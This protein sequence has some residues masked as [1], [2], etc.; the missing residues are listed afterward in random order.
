MG[1]PTKAELARQLEALRKSL[2]R[3][4]KSGV[5][6]EET[7]AEALERQTATAEILRVIASSPGDVQPVFDAIVA[8]AARLC[9][10]EFSAVTKF[11][12]GLLHLVAM[13]NMSPEEAAAYRSIFPRAPGRNFAIGR[14]FVDARPA[15]IRD[16]SKDPDYDPYTLQVL[17]QAAPYRTY[18]G[19]PILRD[20][21]PIGAIGCGR[22]KVKPFTPAQIELVKTF[23]D[24]AVIA[25][26]NVRLFS[27]LQARNADLTE[28]LEQQ[29]ATS[30]ILR[31]ISQ[32]PTDLQPV[33]VAIAANAAGLCD[34]YDAQ[35]FRVEGDSLR[36][37]GSHGP[38]PSIGEFP[39][40]RGNPPGRAVIDRRPIHVTDLAAEADTE[41]PDT[42][43]I[44][45]E[46][47]IRTVLATPLV[48]RGYEVAIA[49]DGEQGLAMARSEAPALILMDMSLPGI[50]GWEATRQLKAAPET[51][52]I[53]IIALTAHAMAGDRERAVA[54]GCDD[55]DTK[56]VELTRLLE[57]IEALLGQTGNA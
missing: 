13:N 32:S 22:R 29:T 5:R 11:E 25:I 53:P 6:L 37:V 24:Q 42:R 20:G 51:Q 36:H 46:L 30:E 47:G 18:L 48:R 39:L 41:F 8:S 10:A 1:S 21:V 17:Q 12:D 45:K 27:E 31:A 15:H 14:A 4:R 3:Q 57:K 52:K 34:A 2:G 23:A 19:I 28:A 43:R 50:D 16:V 56:P 9:D 55:F 26:E 33:M 35:I 38:M 7:L 40:S 44:Q 54:A 49:L